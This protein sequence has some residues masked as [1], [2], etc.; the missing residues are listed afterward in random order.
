MSIYATLVH[1]YEDF[2]VKWVDVF[3]LAHKTVLKLAELRIHCYRQK[4]SVW[5]LVSGDISF[6]RLSSGVP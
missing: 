4:C 1:A 3:W 5:A 2:A 6:M